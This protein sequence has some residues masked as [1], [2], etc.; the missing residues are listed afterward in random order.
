MGASRRQNPGRRRDYN[1]VAMPA[2]PPRR[3]AFPTTR[4][5]LI[6]AA[7]DSSGPLAHEALSTLCSAYWYPIYAYVRRLGHSHD[8]AEDLTQGFFARL[9]EKRYLRDFDRERG[10]F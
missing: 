6:Q 4:I 10:R 1:H 8:E 7:R 5:T 3:D 9:L 2:S